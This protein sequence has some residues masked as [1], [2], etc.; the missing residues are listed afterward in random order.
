VQGYNSLPGAQP[1]NR[2]ELYELWYRQALFDDRLIVRI[3]K[4]LPNVD[5]C[6]VTRPVSTNDESLAIPSVTG[7]LYTP[8]FTPP[9]LLGTIGGYY[10]SVSG[11]SVSVAPTKNTYLRY[12]FYDGNLARGQQTGMMAPQFNGYYFNIWEAGMTWVLAD[13]YPGNVSAG[14]WYQTG[15]LTRANISQNG[16]GG[17][18]MFGSQRIWSNDGEKPSTDDGK[19]TAG[20]RKIRIFPEHQNASI[21]AF[22]QF[23]L[24]DSA[25]MLINQSFGMGVTGF[26]LVPHRPID[27]MG[28][29]MSWAWLNPNIFDRSSELM[30]QGYNQVHLVGSTFFTP[31]ISY[32][33]TPGGGADLGGAWA[34]TCRLAVLF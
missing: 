24:N 26:G 1:L 29:G 32:I 34:V 21:S 2:S 11:I 14:L 9:L 6:N 17:F 7:L 20:K 10:N 23:G 30:F 16:T 12:G 15:V 3:G 4:Q 25:T 28:V 19:I 18:Y 31:A 27:S 22:F 8:T 5:F 33:P 13:K